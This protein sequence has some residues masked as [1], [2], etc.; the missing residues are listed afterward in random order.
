MSVL[1]AAVAFFL[2]VALSAQGGGK[3]TITGT[4][5]D[6]DGEL[7]IGATVRP[8]DKSIQGTVTDI[9]G[10][11]QFS[12]SKPLEVEVTYVGCE[13]QKLTL[14]PGQPAEIHLKG[15]PAALNEVVVVGF[16]TQKKVNLTGAVGVAT[17]KDIEGRPVQSAAAALQGVIPGLNISNSSSGGELNASKSINIRGME[18]IGDGS[19]GGPLILID[20]MEGD[21][22]TL[23]PADIESISVLKDA[24][25]SSIYGSQAP[26]G[27]ILITTKSGTSGK[28]SVKYSD[29][30]R[31]NNP[32]SPM[33]MMDSWE[34]LNYLNDVN[35]YTSKKVRFE[36]D[37]MEQAYQYYIGERDNPFYE[38]EWDGTYRR[39]GKSGESN[40]VFANVNWLDE[41]Y[42]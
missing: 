8:M 15:S 18:T 17:S 34:Y 16:A 1:L 19:K 39:W 6:S 41:L 20:G 13:P 32:L 37:F 11:F 12:Y 22:N 26:F 9:D 4:V 23:N 33:R 2:P 30:F 31:V 38:N 5:Y 29:S 42:K 7:A 40:G 3:N 14:M 24:A 25:A 27:V 36:D 21:M 28:T 35:L 10:V